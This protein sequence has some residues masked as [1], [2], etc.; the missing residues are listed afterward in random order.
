MASVGWVL[1]FLWKSFLALYL[2]C[3]L[4]LSPFLS[5]R[6]WGHWGA[7]VHWRR[8]PSRQWARQVMLLI[9]LHPI[10]QFIY[11]LFQSIM[12][13]YFYQVISIPVFK[14]IVMPISFIWPTLTLNQICC[15]LMQKPGWC[16][17]V[18]QEQLKN[19]MLSL[20]QTKS[21][22]FGKIFTFMTNYC[23]KCFDH[24]IG[25]SWAYGNNAGE[26]KNMKIGL[27]LGELVCLAGA[28]SMH[29]LYPR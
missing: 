4:S 8:R 27:D 28:M 2:K 17:S 11:V 1:E 12:H 18:N 24:D 22:W 29:G 19:Q 5:Y 9:I 20:A 26:A 25:V 13:A 16:I 6:S 14:H 3:G 23:L 7:W 21:T 10:F 15:H